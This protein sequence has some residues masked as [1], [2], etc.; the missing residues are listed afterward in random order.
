MGA[1]FEAAGGAG[2]AFEGVGY[3]G[4]SFRGEKG[5][6]AAF[7]GALLKQ[8]KVQMDLWKEMKVWVYLLKEQALLSVGIKLM[9]WMRSFLLSSVGLLMGLLWFQSN[10]TEAWKWP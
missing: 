5:M 9:I 4:A 8:W 7:E 2:A 6:G 10:I 3:I 1:A